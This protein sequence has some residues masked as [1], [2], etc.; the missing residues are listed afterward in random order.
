MLPVIL[1]PWAALGLSLP[2]VKTLVVVSRS[3][4]RKK[5]G[6]KSSLKD[7]VDDVRFAQA[8]ENAA[9]KEAAKCLCGGERAPDIIVKG[10]S[11]AMK[12][13]T[14][15]ATPGASDIIEGVGIETPPK[16]D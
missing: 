1:I 6:K 5:Q 10:A 4:F 9:Y 11:L 12:C 14:H 2:V 15:L 16:P 13:A 8:A 7:I 3:I